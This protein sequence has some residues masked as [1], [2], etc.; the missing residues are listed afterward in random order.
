MIRV[1]LGGIMISD[2]G[3]PIENISDE[4]IYSPRDLSVLLFYSLAVFITN[5]IY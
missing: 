4:Y 2:R 3:R 1:W 5:V